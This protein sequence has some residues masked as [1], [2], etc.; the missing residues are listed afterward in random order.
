MRY[1]LDNPIVLHFK[2]HYRYASCGSGLVPSVAYRFKR[3]RWCGFWRRW[4]V[5]RESNPY[6]YLCSCI[7]EHMANPGVWFCNESWDFIFDFFQENPALVDLLL[8]FGMDALE[9]EGGNDG[10]ETGQEEG[11]EDG[12]AQ[13]LHHQRD[14]VGA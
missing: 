3:C 8:A 9:A 1:A 4:V 11:Q 10:Q 12:E 13:V 7:G 5:D 14:G 6:I 2:R